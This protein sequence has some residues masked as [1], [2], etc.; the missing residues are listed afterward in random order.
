MSF[1]QSLPPPSTPQPRRQDDDR[2][3]ASIGRMF[4]NSSVTLALQRSALGGDIS[5]SSAPEEDDNDGVAS[6]AEATGRDNGGP[7]LVDRLSTMANNSR[8][9]DI[10]PNH[11]TAAEASAGAQISPVGKTSQLQDAWITRERAKHAKRHPTKAISLDAL[12]R[13]LDHGVMPWQYSKTDDEEGDDDD[14][15]ARTS[16]GSENGSSSSGDD[17]RT[18]ALASSTLNK[19]RKETP[20][21]KRSRNANKRQRTASSSFSG[22]ASSTDHIEENEFFRNSSINS[23][24]NEQNNNGEQQQRRRLYRVRSPPLSPGVASSGSSSSSNSSDSDDGEGRRKHKEISEPLNTLCF[25][26]MWGHRQFDRVASEKL[27]R[28]ADIFDKHFLRSESP[29]LAHLLSLY[30]QAEIYKPGRKTGKN[31]PRWTEN[32]IFIHIEEHILEP[33]VFLAKS[34]RKCIKAKRALEMFFFREDLITQQRMYDE[35]AMRMWLLFDKR[36]SDLYNCDYKGMFGY[37]ENMKIDPSQLSHMVHE[38]RY[39]TQ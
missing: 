12:T 9:P 19:K 13:D 26:C 32:Q 2:G 38:D 22:S 31:F 34:I 16:T 24:D 4:A 27:N 17:E 11:S 29:E 10:N 23:S 5:S 3:Y 6:S 33:R 37:S 39:A 21:K 30:Y 20:K 25:G 7:E 35:K 18:R 14:D 28:M 15:Q 8:V 1:P 36:Q